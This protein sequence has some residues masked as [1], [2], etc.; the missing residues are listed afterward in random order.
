MQNQKM[1]KRMN[2]NGRVNTNFSF[3]NHTH[4][5]S[6]LDGFSSPKEYLERC[7]ELGFEGFG[8]TEHGTEFSWV[9]FDEIKK[10]YDLKMVYGVEFYETEDINIK[11]TNSRYYHLVVL[12]KNE[13]GRVALNKLVTKSNFEGFYYKP[14]IQIDEIA[15]YSD[16][17]VVSTACL[18]SKIA[19]EKD[20]SKCLE[21]VYEYKELFPNFYLEMQS[22]KHEDQVEYN[23]KILKLSKETDTPYVITTDAHSATK[24]DLEYQGWHVKIAQDRETLGEIYDGC[25]IQS[26]DE[27]YDLMIPQIGEENTTKGLLENLSLMDSLEEINMPF[28]DPKT[29]QFEIPT[30]FK[31]ANEYMTHLILEGYKKRKIDTKPNVKVYLDRIKEEMEVISSMD[32]EGY[33]LILQDIM[34]YARSIKIE[35]GDGRGSAGGSL[36]SYLLEITN[37]DP[38]K[39]DLIFSRFLNKE[40]LSYPDIDLDFGDRK[41]IIDYVEKKYGKKSVCQVLNLTY[42]SDKVSIKDV[43]KA[44]NMPYKYSEEIAKYFDNGDFM[45]TYMANKKEIDKQIGMA[46]KECKNRPDIDDVEVF[47]R[48]IEIASKIT[49][50]V[51]Q[52]S[53]HAC[54]LGIVNEEI[55]DYM[56]MHLGSDGEQVIQVDKKMLE[57]IGIVKM[58]ILGV[59]TLNVIGQTLKYIGKD[60]SYID[61]NNEEILNDKGIYDIL[62]SGDTDGIFQVESY[63]MKELCK[64]IKPKY[65]G[66]I[67]AILALYRPDTMLLLESYIDRR[68]GIE[69]IEYLHEDMKYILESDYGITVYQ[70]QVLEI[71]RKF[72]GR[73]Y[74]GADIFRKAIGSKNKEIAQTE[75]KKLYQEIIDSGYSRSIARIISDNLSLLGGY[76]FNR[77]HSYGYSMI[78]IK[79]A[80]LKANHPVEFMAALLNSQIGD[81]AK[82]SKYITSCSKMNIKVSPPHINKSDRLF[83]PN[84]GEILFGLRMIKG[85]G[86]VVTENIIS[87]RNIEKF[88]SL[89]DFI[90][91]T[92]PDI[93][94]KIAL[95]KSGAFG[96]NKNK[97]LKQIFDYGTIEMINK[98]YTSVVT[99]PTIKEL[100]EKWDIEATNKK[101]RLVLYNEKKAILFDREK[102]EKYNKLKEAFQEKY[103][104]NKSKWEFEALNMYITHNPFEKA[105]EEIG[106]FDDKEDGENVVCVGTIIDIDKKKDKNKKYYAFVDFY[107]GEKNI[108]LI[109]WSSQYAK[110]QKGIFK[111]SDIVIKGRK[112]GD[113]VF[114]NQAKPYKNWKESKGI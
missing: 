100:S 20:Y 89:E 90:E 71:V 96:M 39:Y 57:K 80:F 101:D 65:I 56:A 108:E 22:H 59:E 103:C 98:E 63:G 77:S 66:D 84:N 51:R 9:Y 61:I 48:L 86:D 99:C 87:N 69:K 12:A 76:S 21:Y 6:P 43:G 32:F 95:A 79:T 53:I 27:M 41:P 102:I 67:S 72:A 111:G 50:R 4:I 60:S 68:N 88:K 42:I 2:S 36:I 37:L 94:S 15:K 18:G 29:P 70:E 7:Q 16:D 110:F 93:T 10:D 113:K 34:N 64:R 44:L 31:N 75:A 54:A 91:R 5:G 40:R 97:V 38:I 3:H 105:I 35:V 73:S 112:E 62:S 104:M 107:N 78:T 106:N 46:K 23:R 13:R 85:V 30:P 52:T 114:V 47:D 49:G 81:N 45:E 25:Y 83:Y 58:D 11:D 8:I 1:K 28:Q 17:L 74:G 55:T 24:E 14:R 26:L 92:N 33:F 109:F 19:R 82:I